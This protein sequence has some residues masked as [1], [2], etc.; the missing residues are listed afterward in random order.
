MHAVRL[1]ALVIFGVLL[2]VPP[3]GAL[4]SVPAVAQEVKPLPAAE[5]NDVRRALEDGLPIG[6]G[7]RRLE[8]EFPP[9]G[10]GLKGRIC[11]LLTVGSGVHF[12]GPEIRTMVDMHA[13]LKAALTLAGW[14]ETEETRKFTERSVAGR[15]VFALYKNN[16][17]C[18]STVLIGMTPGYSPTSDVKKNDQI[19]LGALSPF[20]REWWIAVDCFHL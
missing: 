8:F 4:R 19:Y 20:Q 7:F 12:E 2:L 3:V 18:V 13:H 6:P 11:R 10:M 14:R 5:C 17:I 9:N 1:T 16:A 15:D